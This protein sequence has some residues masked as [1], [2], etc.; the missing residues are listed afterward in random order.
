MKSP[1]ET[2]RIIARRIA[3]ALVDELKAALSGG[4]LKQEE[5]SQRI[6]AVIHRE[7][8]NSGL[9]PLLLKSMIYR[10]RSGRV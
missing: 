9:S 8:R 7:A 3:K 2:E 4:G 5:C 10:L 6:S 1:T